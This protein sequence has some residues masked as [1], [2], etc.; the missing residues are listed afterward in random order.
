MCLCARA[1][2]ES[3]RSVIRWVE[4]R[5]V[6]IQKNL[7]KTANLG[8]GLD[9]V[10]YWSYVQ[11]M[12]HSSLPVLHALFTLAKLHR[13]TTLAALAHMAAVPLSTARTSL[14]D[15]ERE[16][17][18]W[19]VA[20]GPRL[21]MMGLAATMVSMQA[22]KHAQKHAQKMS[23]GSVGAASATE[24]AARASAESSAPSSGA[25]V[26]AGGA[27]ARRVGERVPASL[28]AA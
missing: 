11:Y 14:L 22:Q 10:R 3:E 21:T 25:S 1:S 9:G 28:R 13:P 27:G 18:V 8:D 15:L 23:Q 7:G 17:Y 4:R 2:G 6:T 24:A 16:G 26:S 5:G 12:H 20:G 19:L